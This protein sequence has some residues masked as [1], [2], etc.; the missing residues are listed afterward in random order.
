LKTSY[1]ILTV[2]I[3]VIIA[4]VIVFAVI[5]L[6]GVMWWSL[7]DPRNTVM[8]SEPTQQKSDEQLCFMTSIS[9]EKGSIVSMERCIPSNTLEAIGCTD[10]ILDHIS[11]YTNLLDDEFDGTVLRNFVGLPDGVSEKEYDLCFNFLHERRTKPFEIKEFES[12]AVL[13]K[14]NPEKDIPVFFEIRLMEQGIEW[15]LADR[16]WTNTD[17]GLVYPAKICSHIIKES[18]AELCIYTILEDDYSLS[19]MVMQREMPNDCAKFF[20]VAE[21]A[22]NED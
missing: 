2:S 16:S 9:G 13:G 21:V 3:V 7:F 20:P 14:I 17:E 8:D 5:P 4:S 22:K 6:A 15:E 19:D 11:R 12:F 1:K 10:L 18:G